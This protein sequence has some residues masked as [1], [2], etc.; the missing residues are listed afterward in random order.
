MISSKFETHCRKNVIS[1]AS[2]NEKQIDNF[3]V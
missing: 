1:A 2:S 3:T